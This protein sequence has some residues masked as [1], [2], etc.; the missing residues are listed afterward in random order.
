M[1]FTLTVYLLQTTVL[2]QLVRNAPPD[3]PNVYLSNVTSDQ[4]EGLEAFLRAEPGVDGEV[5]LLPVV[6]ARLE[7]FGEGTP[8]RTG[9]RGERRERR[10][11]RTRDITWSDTPPTGLTVLEGRWWGA[12]QAEPVVSVRDRLADYLDLELGSLV[13]W[14]VAGKEVT[15][16]V[17][18]LH[19][20]EGMPDWIYDFVLNESA[21]R[22]SPATYIG[23]FRA[24]PEHNL[25]LSRKAF[26]AFPSVLYISAVDFFETVQEVI[27]QIAFVVRFV[28]AFAIA[29]GVI[30]LVSSVAATRFRRLREV[31]VLKTLGATK[32]RLAEIFSIEFLILGS[33]AGAAGSLLAVSYS[34][35]LTWDILDLDVVVEWPAI[36][37]TVAATAVL[38]TGAGW[39]ASLRILGSKPLE[40]L[41]DE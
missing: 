11:R 8:G 13:T 14:R 36:A 31:A 41:R 27:D 9:G 20:F 3:M 37:L 6:S 23:G 5:M 29:A 34:A 16:R 10:L 7:S 32:G 18:A 25:E 38:A 15:A 1:T 33:V 39:G 12:S 24:L 21:L 40:I 4:R 17:A 30:I 26:D 28:S 19:S 22:G 35:L 2:A